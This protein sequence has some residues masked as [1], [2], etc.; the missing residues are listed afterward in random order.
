VK[1]IQ[2]G[3]VFHCTVLLCS[4]IR[5][6]LVGEFEPCHVPPSEQILCQICNP[7]APPLSFVPG[8]DALSP[9]PYFGAASIDST[10]G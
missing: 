9:L 7:S 8:A 1:Y 6:V 4:S 5:S 2:L 3:E 10:E